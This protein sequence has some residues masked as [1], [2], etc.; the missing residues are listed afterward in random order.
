LM[1]PKSITCAV[2][3]PIM[4]VLTL[5][6]RLNSILHGELMGLVISMLFM[7]DYA[8]R[9]SS[10]VHTIYMDH[11]NS[12]RLIIDAR[13]ALD[14]TPKLRRMN[15]W[16]LYRWILTNLENTKTKMTYTQGHSN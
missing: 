11:L 2:T 16:S 4:M 1:D 14:V 12:E 9:S 3:G 5:K 6:D 10:S 7:R 15:G 8:D 13:T